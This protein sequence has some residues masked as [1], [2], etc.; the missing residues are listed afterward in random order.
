M[1]TT[2]SFPTLLQMTNAPAFIN[3]ISLDVEGQELR[4]LR[5]FPFATTKVGAWIVERAKRAPTHV[6]R[7]EEHIEREAAAR[8]VMP[9]ENKTRAPAWESGVQWM[10][11][12]VEIRLSFPALKEA[13]EKEDAQK[14]THL[15]TSRETVG[16]AGKAE[17]I[18]RFRYRACSAFPPFQ[19]G[20]K[21]AEAA[22]SSSATL[23]IFFPHQSL[24]GGGGGGDTAGGAH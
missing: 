3:A 19:L 18:T 9:W 8:G 7:R 6:T 13:K 2:I 5:R 22:W 1:A 14:E 12:M 21:E 10:K 23:Q 11:Q 16:A 20:R 4:A 24:G 17:E 15:V